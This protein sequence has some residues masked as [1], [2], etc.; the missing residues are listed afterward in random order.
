MTLIATVK[1]EE[2]TGQVAEIY[3]QIA[4]RMGRVP[5][6]MQVLSL[7]PPLLAARWAQANYYASNPRLSGALLATVRLLVSEVND[8]AY[9]VEYNAALLVNH[10]G[11]TMAQI[12]ATRANPAKAPLPPREVALLV[13]V[14]K[15]HATP[16]HI[17]QEDMAAL[18]ALDWSDQ[19]VLDVVVHAATNRA[20]DMLLNVFQVERDF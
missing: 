15:A 3:S 5:A 9:C 17:G 20:V 11:Q 6:A 10:F 13:F 2:A 18:H 16:H 19:D 7:S 4:E 12:E 1:P 8:C 14:M